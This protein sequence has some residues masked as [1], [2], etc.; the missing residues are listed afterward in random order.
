LSIIDPN[1]EIGMYLANGIKFETTVIPLLRSYFPKLMAKQ[2]VG[3]QP[4]QSFDLSKCF[5]MFSEKEF[6]E[7]L[8]EFIKKEE[9]RV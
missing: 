7:S 3:V 2:L 6:L 8:E 4:M 9:F 1:T 5:P